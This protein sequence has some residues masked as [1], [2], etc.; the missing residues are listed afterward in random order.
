MT[1]ARAEDGVLAVE[2]A[3]IAPAVL[4][5]LL[6][7]IYVAR[8]VG[9]DTQ[10]QTAAARAARAASLEANLDAATAAATTAAESNLGGAGV[11]CQQVHVRIDT[12]HLAAGATVTVS[13]GCQV[14]NRDLALLAVPGARWS[15]ARA[16]H[17][18]DR[19]RGGG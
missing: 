16:V 1:R 3:V 8:A 19:Y 14:A 4:V 5:L 9:A 2:T 17:V 7:V 6:L 15:T 11:T 12:D 18:V 13:V 10:V